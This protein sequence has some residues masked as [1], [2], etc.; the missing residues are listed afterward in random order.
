MLLSSCKLA[1]RCQLRKFSLAVERTGLSFIMQG[2]AWAL[3]PWLRLSSDI[4]I[5]ETCLATVSG[6]QPPCPDFLLPQHIQHLKHRAIAFKVIV[7]EG[8]IDSSLSW[9][10]RECKSD[11]HS[12]CVCSWS[13]AQLTALS[14]YFIYTRI[15]PFLKDSGQMMTFSIFGRTK[16]ET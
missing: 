4:I 11:R 6:L 14:F 5:P 16:D 8:L 10:P 1:H 13:Q 9:S 15:I 12:L 3:L 7:C 2:L